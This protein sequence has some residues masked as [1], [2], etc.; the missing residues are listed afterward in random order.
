[1]KNVIFLLSIAIAQN[2]FSSVEVTDALGRG[3]YSD[4]V[5]IQMFCVE[6]NSETSRCLSSRFGVRNVESEKD[7]DFLGN[8]ILNFELLGDNYRQREDL[9]K[10]LLA[11]FKLSKVDLVIEALKNRQ[12]DNWQ[13]K[14]QRVSKKI[15]QKI[16]EMLRARDFE[17]KLEQKNREVASALKVRYAE[18]RSRIRSDWPESREQAIGEISDEELIQMAIGQELGACWILPLNGPVPEDHI[19]PGVAVNVLFFGI[20]RIGEYSHVSRNIEIA[21]RIRSLHKQSSCLSHIAEKYL[22]RIQTLKGL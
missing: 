11:G 18:I 22:R 20:K 4:S 12:H 1:M 14:P 8:D 9:K 2:S 13:F 19:F 5:V 6:R 16:V 17:I 7:D 3:I 15:V 10:F 21:K